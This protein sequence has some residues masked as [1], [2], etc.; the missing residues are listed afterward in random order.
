VVSY[1]PGDFDSAYESYNTDTDTVI[2]S[3]SSSVTDEEINIELAFGY[4]YFL[5]DRVALGVRGRAFLTNLDAFGATATDPL[6][7]RTTGSDTS[8][9]T[10]FNISWRL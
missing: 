7:A 9:A 5:T 4:S 1:G 2:D 8:F 10:E 6:F 3:S